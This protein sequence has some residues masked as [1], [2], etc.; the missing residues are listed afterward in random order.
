MVIPPLIEKG[1][2]EAVHTS[3]KTMGILPAAM[4][5][6]ISSIGS[7][8]VGLPRRASFTGNRGERVLNVN[9]AD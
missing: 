1:I 2:E 7:S 9:V 5:L 3:G 4:P 8:L 6:A